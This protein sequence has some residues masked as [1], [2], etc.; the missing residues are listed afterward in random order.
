MK[1]FMPNPQT[2]DV[3]PHTFDGTLRD[4]GFDIMRMSDQMGVLAADPWSS[5]ES[6]PSRYVTIAVPVSIPVDEDPTIEVIPA[7][8]L[9]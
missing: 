9:P 3:P 5:V 2:G 4:A 7:T 6:Y 1:P 8:Q